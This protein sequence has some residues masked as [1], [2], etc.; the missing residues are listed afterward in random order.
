VKK[1]LLLIF[2]LLLFFF[3]TSKAY[4]NH[5][6]FL[7]FADEEENFLPGQY[8]FQGKK[9]YTDIFVQHQPLA[10]IGSG[11]IQKIV[12]PQTISALVKTHRYGI[13]LWSLIWSII[14]I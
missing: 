6:F 5:V 7:D 3:F 11:V 9:L 12:H 2:L 10:Y 14:L 8:I 13:I 1:K 4:I